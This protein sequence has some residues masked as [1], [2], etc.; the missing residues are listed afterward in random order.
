[1]SVGLEGALGVSDSLVW[2]LGV[3][4]IGVNG[5]GGVSGLSAGAGGTVGGKIDDGPAVAGTGGGASGACGCGG[6]VG[7]GGAGAVGTV[8]LAIVDA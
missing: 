6:C 1:M 7:A 3:T 5:E 4:V 8:L 2:P